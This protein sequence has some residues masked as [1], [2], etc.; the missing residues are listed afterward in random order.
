M[1]EVIADAPDG[2]APSEPSTP[3]DVPAIIVCLT[4]R[5]LA[6]FTG[7][8][9]RF[10]RAMPSLA[11]D[12]LRALRSL[13]ELY[14][15]LVFV[16][17]HAGSSHAP[18]VFDD[19]DVPIVPPALRRYLKTLHAAV[20]S[21]SYALHA[22]PSSDADAAIDW[23]RD[24]R[25]AC[26]A[27]SVDRLRTPLE[28]QPMYALGHAITAMESMRHLR[29]LIVSLK[30]TFLEALTAS[31][32]GILD[33]F[34]A[35]A[36]VPAEM[37]AKHVY[38]GIARNIVDIE[39]VVSAI[40]NRSWAPKEP[41]SQHNTYMDKCLEQVKQLH[42]ALGRL[43]IPPSDAPLP[44]PIHNAVLEEAVSFLAERLVDA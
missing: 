8:Y 43:T 1:N 16:T 14:L 31:G 4:A 2:P 20:S 28:S 26:A 10:M 37:M 23:Q 3:A 25:D 11:I 38:R 36:L 44:T 17:F 15:Y 12:T 9:V 5:S 27:I 22:L 29:Q 19:S 6:S 34:V 18:A 39:E 7:R 24:V 42:S 41:Q 32:A 13:Y 35:E 40:R 33:A 21:S 30:P